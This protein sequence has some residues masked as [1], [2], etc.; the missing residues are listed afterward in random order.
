MPSSFDAGGAHCVWYAKLMAQ[1][2]FVTGP[3]SAI[4]GEGGE[5]EYVIPSS[6]MNAAMSRY[7]RGA[8]GEGVIP[9]VAAATVAT[10][11]QP[12]AP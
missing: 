9:A 12:L 1:G 4:I 6:K 5:S 8:R 11:Q 3:T 2:G 10:P 7:S